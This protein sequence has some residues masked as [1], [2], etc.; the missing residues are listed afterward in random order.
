MY[1][2][3]YVWYPWRLEESAG[4][5]RIEVTNVSGPPCGFWEL[6]LGPLQ[7]QQII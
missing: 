4:L 7:E 6:I 1:T 5:P 3:L 2:C